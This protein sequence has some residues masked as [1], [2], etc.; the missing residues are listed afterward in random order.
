MPAPKAEPKS[1]PAAARRATPLA[2]PK[3]PNQPVAIPPP[4]AI[5]PRVRPP[6][7]ASPPEL[8]RPTAPSI[9]VSVGR[10]EV[11]T[12]TPT[13]AEPETPTA[14]PRAH[15]IDPG[16]PFGSVFERGR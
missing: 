3:P 4:P 16:L 9:K 1:A 6:A 13:F 10:V 5:A 11:K 7:A 8:P 2:P 14:M 12:Q 15:G